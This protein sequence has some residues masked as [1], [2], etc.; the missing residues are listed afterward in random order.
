LPYIAAVVDLAEGPRVMTNVVGVAA[1]DLRIGMDLVV[2]FRPHDDSITAP[3][4]RPA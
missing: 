2:D 4:F 1:A 3:V